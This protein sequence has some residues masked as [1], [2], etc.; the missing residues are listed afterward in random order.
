MK[1]TDDVLAILADGRARR[2]SFGLSLA[3]SKDTRT[4]QFVPEGPKDILS[5]GSQQHRLEY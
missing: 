3:L 1:S 4:Q 2:H 5:A